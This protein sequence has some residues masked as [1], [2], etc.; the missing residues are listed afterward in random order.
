MLGNANLLLVIINTVKLQKHLNAKVF[1]QNFGNGM[2]QDGMVSSSV[3]SYIELER[4]MRISVAILICLLPSLCRAE[5]RALM[6]SF[7]ITLSSPNASF[8]LTVA[9]TKR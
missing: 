9:S 2:E 1:S 8:V 3:F 4:F 6:A 7:R 5:G